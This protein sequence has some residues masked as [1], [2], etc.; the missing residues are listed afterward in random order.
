LA[1][2][3]FRVALT[4]IDIDD[5][6]RLDAFGGQ[7]P[8]YSGNRAFDRFARLRPAAATMS[9]QVSVRRCD[10]ARVTGTGYR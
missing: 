4:A 2:E 8:I 10:P 1:A 6:L 5:A 9:K 7:H 3:R